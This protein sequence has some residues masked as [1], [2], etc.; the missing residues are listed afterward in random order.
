MKAMQS[1][2]NFGSLI[3]RSYDRILRED[4]LRA[5]HNTV[6]VRLPKGTEYDQ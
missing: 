6:Y 2:M 4:Y 5:I 3:G 1:F